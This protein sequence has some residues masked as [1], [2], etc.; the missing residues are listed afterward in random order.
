VTS[1]LRIQQDL[2]SFLPVSNF[3]KWQVQNFSDL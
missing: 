3:H 2:Q 1:W